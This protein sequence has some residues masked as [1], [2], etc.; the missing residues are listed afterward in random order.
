MLTPAVIAGA[1]LAIG[2]LLGI[3]RST[4]RLSAVAP[5]EDGDDAVEEVS[6]GDLSAIIPGFVEPCKMVGRFFPS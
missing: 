5:E 1:S 2:Y 4:Q 6:D 3:Q